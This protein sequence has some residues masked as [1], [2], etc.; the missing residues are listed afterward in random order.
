MTVS[1][2]LDLPVD[3]IPLFGEAGVPIVVATEAQD[4][5]L[6]HCEADVEVWR[7]GVGE[8]TFPALLRDLRTRRGV[9]GVTCEGGPG[10]LRAL[11][12]QNGLDELLLTIAP[13][14]VAGEAL[15]VLQGDRFAERGLDLE[16]VDVHRS[17]HHMFLR[18]SVPSST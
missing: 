3:E 9:R 7:Y 12:A 4:G 2:R 18:Y 1:R 14:L 8:L 5:E 11:L 15:T 17:G 16:L 10:L 6:S 13:K